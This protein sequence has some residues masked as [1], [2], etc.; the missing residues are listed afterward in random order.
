MV[1]RFLPLSGL[2][3]SVSDYNGTFGRSTSEIRDVYSVTF[4]LSRRGRKATHPA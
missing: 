3:G 2:L 4:L 1:S